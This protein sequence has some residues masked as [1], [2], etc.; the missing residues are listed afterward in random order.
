MCFHTVGSMCSFT[1]NMRFG[2]NKGLKWPEAAGSCS[3]ACALGSTPRAGVEAPLHHGL[4]SFCCVVADVHV[5]L[6]LNLRQLPSNLPTC[7]RGQ[8]EEGVPAGS[9][10]S[11]RSRETAGVGASCR[12]EGG[13]AGGGAPRRGEGRGGVSLRRCRKLLEPCCASLVRLC[14]MAASCCKGGREVQLHQQVSSPVTHSRGLGSYSAVG[15]V[16]YHPREAPM[17]HEVTKK[18]THVYLI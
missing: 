18:V 3:P 9:G 11:Y 12:R 17:L 14:H 4:G 7:R 13:P 10:R 15:W 8:P 16:T 6:H 2:L 1:S 5:C